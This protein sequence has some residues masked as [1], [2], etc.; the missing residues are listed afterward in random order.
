[1][2]ILPAL[3]I[4][5]RGDAIFHS[6]GGGGGGV[7]VIRGGEQLMNESLSLN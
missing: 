1:M 3:I 2:A 6:G 5:R 7:R 4:G